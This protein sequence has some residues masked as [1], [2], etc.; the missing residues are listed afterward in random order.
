MGGD[1]DQR[2][3]IPTP[4]PWA[5]RRRHRHRL[6]AALVI[7]VLGLCLSYQLLVLAFQYREYIYALLPE[8]PLPVQRRE[9]HI[10]DSHRQPSDRHPRILCL[11]VTSPKYHDTRSSHVAATWARH[12]TRAVFLST[13]ED[14]RL[15]DVFITPG[16]ASYEQLWGKVTQGFEWAYGKRH[17]FDWVVKAD[18][19]TFLVVE[20]L[21]AALLRLDPDQAL[22]TGVQL[23]TW[24][25]GS[26]YFNGG[27]G[28][29]LSRGAVSLLVEEGLRRRRCVDDL[30][31]G[32]FEDVSMALC[33]AHLDVVFLDSRDPL[34]RQRFHMYPPHE[35]IDPRQANSITH[36][37]LKRQSVFPYKFGYAGLSDEAISFHYV[38]A[39]SMYLLYYLVYVVNPNNQVT[40]IN[41]V[42]SRGSQ[43]KGDKQV[44]ENNWVSL[45]AND[46]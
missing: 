29:V 12:C 27:A 8:P 19:D 21:Q 32:V 33:L 4:L 42:N 16:A 36:L 6:A 2:M 44:K 41:Q 3:R 17:D 38:D 22:A 30:N 25:T 26:I 43:V 24:D 13:A 1:D 14:S 45:S 34:G 46:K 5:I 28:Y 23:R 39:R 18:D 40:P 7:G 35:L 11:I 9:V 37:W 31:L 15:P 10:P 20:N